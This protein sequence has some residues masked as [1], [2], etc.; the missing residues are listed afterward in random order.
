MREELLLE[1][2]LTDGLDAGLSLKALLNISIFLALLLFSCL[3]L[4][5]VLSIEGLEFLLLFEDAAVCLL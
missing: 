1:L 2:L 4:K 3:E 5:L